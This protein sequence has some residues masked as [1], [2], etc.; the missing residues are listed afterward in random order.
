METMKIKDLKKLLVD[1]EQEHGDIDELDLLSANLEEI[2][3]EIEFRNYK[4]VVPLEEYGADQ[5]KRKE[6]LKK[7][8][9]KV[10]KEAERSKG[11]KSLL[12]RPINRSRSW[13]ST[14]FN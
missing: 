8:Y 2:K 9:K 14:K 11:K 7:I 3:N 13:C 10:E 1:L 12:Y 5:E 4:L 6:E